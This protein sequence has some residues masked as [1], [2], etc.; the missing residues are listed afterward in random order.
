MHAGGAWFRAGPDTEGSKWHRD[1]Y[2]ENGKGIQKL[3]SG[4]DTG[5]ETLPADVQEFI[6]DDSRRATL[7]ALETLDTAA[8]TDFDHLTRL[9]ASMMKAPIALVS[10]V[11]LDR[12][13]FKSCIG[14]PDRE[15]PIGMSFCAHTIAGS[16]DVMVIENA[17]ED[18]RFASN[19][20]VTGAPNIRFYAGAPIAVSGEKIGTLCVIDHVPRKRPDRV[21]LDQLKSLAALASTLFALKDNTRKGG[22]V[23]AALVREEKRHALALEAA[24]I[25]SWVWHVESDIV[26]CDPLLPVL[27]NVPHATRIKA[28]DLYFAID[29]RDVTETEAHLKRAL[30]ESDDYSGEYRVAGVTPPRWLAV[31]GKVIERDADGKPALVYGVNFDITERRTSEERQRLLLR[32]VNHRVKNTLA[33]VQALATQTVRHSRQPREFLEAFS[34]RLHALGLAHSLLSDNEWRG[35][36]LKEL[37]RLQVMPFDDRSAPRIDVFGE[38]V[39]LNPDQALA[40]GLILYELASNALKYGSLSVPAGKVELSWTTKDDGA[41]PRLAISWK[42][43][44]G[45]AV[46]PPEHHGF[47]SILIQRSLGK[48]LSSNVKHEFLLEGVSAEISMP[49]DQQAA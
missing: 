23:H 10:L 37:I 47:G 4:K 42:E 25:A 8:D 18:A 1:N 40:L 20:L 46:E 17:T 15:I 41:S 32:E 13:W 38:E 48:V 29:S 44:G 33:T 22:L 14:L 9:A 6:K 21:E 24:T 39:L 35:I 30:T 27:F 19:P 7:R 11:D 2:L 3:Q 45:P 43:S 31:R 5:V 28:S 12:Q 16:D 34:G 49:L 36:G 26:E